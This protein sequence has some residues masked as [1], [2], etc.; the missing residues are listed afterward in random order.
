MAVPSNSTKTFKLNNG[1]SIPAVGLGTWQSTDEEAYNAVIAALKAGYRHIDTAYCYGNE[2]PIGKAI[3][4]SGVARKDIFITTKLWGTDHTRAEEGL[5]R[6]L[7][8]LGL[9]YVDLFLMHWPVPMNP[10]GNHDKFPTLPD[11]KRDILFDWNFVDTYREMQKLVASG[12]TK[13][14]GVSNFSITNLKKLLADPEITTKPVVNQVETHGYLPQQK[15][16]EYAKENDI[17]L[18]AYSPLG[19][20]GAPLLKDELVQELAK[21]NGISESTLLISWAVWRGIVVLPKSVTPSRIADNLKIIELCEEDGK[22]L[23]E[24][25]SIRGEKRLVSPPWDP[26][27]VFNDED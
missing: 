25:A 13:A 22:K 18:E 15:L 5:D 3:K 8:L 4:D 26:I 1:L 20:T 23:N 19:S 7:K 27:V 6:S 9:D 21:K 16:L 10:N 24:L 11:G 17:V 12:K 2:E 14:I